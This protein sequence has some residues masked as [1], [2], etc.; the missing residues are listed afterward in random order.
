MRVIIDHNRKVISCPGVEIKG[1]IPSNVQWKSQQ[2]GNLAFEKYSF[3]PLLSSELHT[4]GETALQE[5]IDLVL[6]NHKGKRI[7]ILD[8]FSKKVE[9]TVGA[10]SQ[11]MALKPLLQVNQPFHSLSISGYLYALSMNISQAV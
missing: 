10:V 7:Q 3:C 4:N 6:E 1:I 11:I 5:M 2:R 9:S 8:M